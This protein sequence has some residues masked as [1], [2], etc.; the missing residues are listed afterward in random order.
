MVPGTEDAT[1]EFVC[2]RARQ[3][4][5]EPHSLRNPPYCFYGDT[6]DAWSTTV[7]RAMLPGIKRSSFTRNDWKD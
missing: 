4:Q 2:E 3:R 7:W 1:R 6:N 5:F